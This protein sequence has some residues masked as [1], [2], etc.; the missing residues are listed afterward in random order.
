[1]PAA[2]APGFVVDHGARVASAMPSSGAGLMDGGFVKKSQVII[3]TIIIIYIYMYYITYTCIYI[4][5]YMHIYIYVYAYIY[6]FVKK[7]VQT[8]NKEMISRYGGGRSEIDAAKG[9][10]LSQ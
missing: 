10:P 9:I 4:Y 8:Y 7:F 2:P 6:R 1:M 5:I 3:V